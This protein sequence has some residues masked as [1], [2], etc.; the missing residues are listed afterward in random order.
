MDEVLEF[1]VESAKWKPTR[2]PYEFT[3]PVRVFPSAEKG[4]TLT[5]PCWERA[6]FQPPSLPQEVTRWQLRARVQ[7]DRVVGWLQCTG[8]REMEKAFQEAG[9][10]L[11]CALFRFPE[12]RLS[13]P[14]TLPLPVSGDGEKE[15]DMVRC[16]VAR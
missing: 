7:G 9:V 13:V 14:A 5:V 16:V 1:S 2:H 6:P 3:V 15:E 8:A 4:R 12:L 11:P 10:V